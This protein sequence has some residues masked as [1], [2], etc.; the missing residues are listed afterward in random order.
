MNAILNE[1]MKGVWGATVFG[2]VACALVVV[3]TD[4]YARWKIF[5]WWCISSVL[6]EVILYYF[7]G[8][9]G[10]ESIR[11]FI[12]YCWMFV[13]E[14]LVIWEAFRNGEWRIQFPIEGQLLIGI[15]G[16]LLH[17]FMGAWPV[18]YFE[19]AARFVN[20]A[21]ILWCIHFFSKQ[22]SNESND[23]GKERHGNRR[24]EEEAAS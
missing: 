8:H 3:A 9:F 19:C 15:I 11:K 23:G 17:R 13:I 20:L 1:L 22:I 4:R 7:A 10:Y 2:N 12:F 18:Y 16:L 5:V 21:V 24:I 6:C 14:P